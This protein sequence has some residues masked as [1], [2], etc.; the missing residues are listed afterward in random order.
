MYVA[1][2]LELNPNGLGGVDVN[3]LE[4][5]YEAWND[6]LLVVRQLKN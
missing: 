6:V 4:E 5:S 3:N 2:L 1:V